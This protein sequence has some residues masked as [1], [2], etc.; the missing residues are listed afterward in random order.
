MGD[1]NAG[2]KALVASVI[3]AAS[4]TFLWYTYRSRREQQEEEEVER[5]DVHR[6]CQDAHLAERESLWTNGYIH[7]GGKVQAERWCDEAVQACSSANEDEEPLPIRALV[8]GCGTGGPSLH[9]AEH[10]GVSVWGYDNCKEAV[11]RAQQLCD[12]QDTP[13]F[14]LPVF[15]HVDDFTQEPVESGFDMVWLVEPMYLGFKGK[16]LF[17]KVH[18]VLRPGGTVFIVDYC[19]NDQGLRACSMHFSTFVQ[20]RFLDLCT[21]SQ[22]SSRLQAAGLEVTS[23]RDDTELMLQLTTNELSQMERADIGG[24]HCSP[25]FHQDFRDVWEGK[26]QWL[27]KDLRFVVLHAKRPP[28]CR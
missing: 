6:Y 3:T 5:G 11:Q 9:M 7:S 24:S 18:D 17:Q 25:S 20:S 22:Y 13:A 10:H 27:A 23:C 2:K 4:A 28:T 26:K 19:C 14:V 8:V 1:T 16:A 12:T 21:M 15:T